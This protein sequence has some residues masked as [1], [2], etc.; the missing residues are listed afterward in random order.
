MKT[1][2]R[3]VVIAAICVPSIS[4]AG[5]IT[6]PTSLDSLLPDGDFVAVGD[7]TFDHFNYI[8]GGDMPAASQ[9]N[10]EAAVGGLRFTGPFLDLPGGVGNGASD[11]TL[12]FTV[13]GGVSEVSLSGN[14]SLLGG[15]GTGIASVT[16]TFAGIGDTKLDIYDNGSGVGLTATTTIAHTNSLTVIKDILLLSTDPVQ[17]ATLSVIEQSFVPEPATMSM[18]LMGLVGLGLIRRRR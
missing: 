2:L 1:L 3:A 5:Q 11:A 6:L 12:G 14:P 7:L 18:V 13:M 8:A 17:S 4:N 10:V 16:E 15:L 9:I